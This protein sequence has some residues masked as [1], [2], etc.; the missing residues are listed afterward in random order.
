MIQKAA[1]P[2]HQDQDAGSIRI[3]EALDR[4]LLSGPF[5]GSKQ[6]QTLL[7]FLVENSLKNEN[8]T[9][10]ERTIGVEVFGRPLDYNTADDPI[11]RAR[12]GEVRK[13]LAQYYLGAEGQTS[14]VKI[15]IK[16]GS[17]RPTFIFQS[18][19]G[20]PDKV[21]SPEREPSEAVDNQIPR[22][23]A[24]E[25]PLVRLRKPGHFRTWMWAAAAV[26]LGAIFFAAWIVSTQSKE[27]TLDRFWAPILNS[28][29]TVLIYTGTNP[30]YMPT[31]DFV[32]NNY[33]THPLGGDE[34]PGTATTLAHLQPEDEL[35]SKNVIPMNSHFVTVGDITANVDV[36]S[37]LTTHH[38][39][40]DLRSGADISFGELRKSSAVLIGAFDNSWTLEMT[41][42]LSFVFVDG[43]IQERDGQKRSWSTVY[44]PDGTIAEDYAVVSRLLD[45]KTGGR[46]ITIAGIFD[47]GTRAA[48]EFI[49]DPVKFK[50]LANVPRGAWDRDNFQIV[51]HAAFKNQYPTSTDVVAIRYW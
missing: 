18:S 14:S 36:A 45:V 38:R 7:R 48:S 51:L 44:A 6:C 50:K 10:K 28:G 34:V 31:H 19:L 40:F 43:H 22:P 20:V 25:P 27:T 15:T 39:N 1:T 23:P 49:T 11:V 33:S 37:L 12:V 4:I 13:R 35:T 8:C 3:D 29:K 16:S 46:I 9:L 41:G 24:H 2:H 47:C 30:V 42:D 26:S 21:H 5:K 32:E 17:Y